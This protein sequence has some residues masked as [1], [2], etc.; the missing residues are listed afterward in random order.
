MAC[1]TTVDVWMVS[2]SHTVWLV[3]LQVLQLYQISLL[4]HGLMMVGPSG[5]GK[6]T[7]WR[8]L[9]RA[10]ERMEGMEGVVHVIEPKVRPSVWRAG[11]SC[12]LCA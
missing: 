1:L 6:S 8:V 4:S 10:L 9:M 12:S 2:C 11:G 3:L 5:S 7:A